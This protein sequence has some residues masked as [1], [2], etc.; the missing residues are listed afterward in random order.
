MM[1][2]DAYLYRSRLSFP[3]RAKPSQQLHCRLP[4]HLHCHRHSSNTVV[5]IKMSVSPSIIPFP[6][7]NYFRHHY[8]GLLPWRHPAPTP[9]SSPLLTQT[10]CRIYTQVPHLRSELS[11]QTS[12]QKRPLRTLIPQALHFNENINALD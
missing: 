1:N 11:L 8:P 3:H 10:C 5:I 12:P 4:F 9:P 6:I 7:I 2:D